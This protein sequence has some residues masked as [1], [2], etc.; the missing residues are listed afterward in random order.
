MIQRDAHLKFSGDGM[1]YDIVFLDMDGIRTAVEWARREGW[2]PGL[3]DA[4][5]FA[6]QDPEG[7]LGLKVDGELAATISLVSY[8]PSFGFLGF[9][10]CRP[11]L[12]G[13]GLGLALWN[14]ALALKPARTIGL[15]GVT[16]QQ[17]NYRKTGFVLAHANFRHGGLKPNGY[18]QSDRSLSALS[19]ADASAIDRFEQRHRLVLR[20]SEARKE[21]SLLF[22]SSHCENTMG[23]RAGSG[24][25]PV[26]VIFEF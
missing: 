10:I 12:R 14:A 4:E 20:R 16:A 25:R 15:D 7:F 21:E 6:A 5:A 9:Y 24:F 26:K 19:T 23:G 18:A 3:K 22:A 17:D 8:G 13:K 1:G 11:D 2:N